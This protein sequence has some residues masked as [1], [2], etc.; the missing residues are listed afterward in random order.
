MV[1]SGLFAIPAFINIILIKI[2]RLNDFNVKG[3]W[4]LLLIIPGLGALW[5]L[6]ILMIAGT[7]GPN[8][9][10][11]ELGE[12]PRFYRFLILSMPITGLILR[13]SGFHFN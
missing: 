2:R 6:A 12:A 5:G 11:E 4:V 10:G 7:K 8:R 13:F 3:W 1:V 9:F